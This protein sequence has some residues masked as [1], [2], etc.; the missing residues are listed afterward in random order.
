MDFPKY[1][2]TN[3]KER[4]GVHQVGLILSSIG[5][6]FRETSNS[7][8]GID[9]QIEYIDENNNATGHI[10]AVQIKSGSSYLNDNGDYW[11]F[12]A[13]DAHKN[14]WNNYA[15]PVLLFVFNPNDNNIYYVNVSIALKTTARINIP[16]TNILNED[17]KEFFL[18]YCLNS[19]HENVSP[20][21]AETT[22]KPFNESLT[23]F[24]CCFI[25]R[26]FTEGEYQFQ[27]DLK[28]RASNDDVT[29][30]SIELCNKETFT[31]NASDEKKYLSLKYF[32]R[33][34][35]INIR[36]V[37]IDDFERV[38]KFEYGNAKESVIDLFI[39]KNRQKSFSFQG[40]IYTI[41]QM[42]GCDDLQ[43]NGWSI[44]ICYDVDKTL[45]IPIKMEIIKGKYDFYDNR[46]II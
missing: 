38:V 13:D 46:D 34:N 17:N 4:I 32:I 29:I 7:D 15:I 20:N 28:L 45:D 1:S 31:G 36:N 35:I 18:S 16:K 40:V 42:D 23:A 3:Q 43:R 6:I 24:E 26:C 19:I 12:H 22:S 44:H 39:A 33:Q 11:S 2:N 10:I 27:I 21:A 37:D 30:K 25:V 5:L 41:R 14:Y 8:T 9:G